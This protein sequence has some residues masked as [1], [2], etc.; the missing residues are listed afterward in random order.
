[1]N[2]QA[3]LFIHFLFF[4]EVSVFSTKSPPA[5]ACFIDQDYC[6]QSVSTKISYDTELTPISLQGIEPRT[7]A[8]QRQ[9]SKLFLNS[10]YA[11]TLLITFHIRN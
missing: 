4:L 6:D 7:A 2:L 3:Q 9:A 1:V 5:A 11:F 8:P 10:N